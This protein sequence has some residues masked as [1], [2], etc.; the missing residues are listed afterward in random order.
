MSADPYI[1]SAVS[2]ASPRAIYWSGYCGF[3]K[4]FDLFVREKKNAKREMQLLNMLLLYLLRG[5]SPKHNVLK[6][7]IVMISKQQMAVYR[8]AN[9][10]NEQS[11]NI[12]TA[13][14]SSK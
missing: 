8:A 5:D 4:A 3:A 13:H 10:L 12:V 2:R 1:I 7:D 9:V 6:R 14:K 11:D